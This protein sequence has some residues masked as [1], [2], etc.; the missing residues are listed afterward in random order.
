[1][2]IKILFLSPLQFFLN[3]NG[4][5]CMCPDS[6]VGEKG[7]INGLEYELVDNDLLRLRRNQGAVLTRLCTSL[8]TDMKDLFVGFPDYNQPLGTWD[9]SNVTNM[10]GMFNGSS[11]NRPLENWDVSGVTD[12][13]EMFYFSSFNQDISNWCVSYFSSEPQNF[14]TNS[15]LTSEYKPK[16]GTCPD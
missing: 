2:K 9:V 12:M 7:I 16:W 13:S 15:H 4:V 6:Q 3:E 8:I 14:S 1:M 10:S 5:T 11:Y